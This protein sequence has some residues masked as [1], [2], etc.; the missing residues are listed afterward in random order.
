MKNTIIYSLLICITISV[1]CKSG[2]AQANTN[3]KGKKIALIIA[4]GDFRDEEYEQPKEYF[5][6]NG[7]ITT[8]VS[9]TTNEV[10]G[11]RGMKAKPQLLLKDMQVSNYDGIVFVGGPGA[12]NY[13]KNNNAMRVI[14]DAA[15]K[16][17]VIAAICVAP[18]IL[19]NAGILDG[20][21]ATAWS[22]EVSG[23][24][25]IKSSKSVETD[26]NIVTANG[27]GAA[28]DFAKAIGTALLKH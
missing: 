13:Y 28:L 15:K 16:N 24:N 20:K 22:F 14:K 19:C 4:P 27:P 18:N 8:T 1:Y 26:G 6:S 9:T 21:K 5:E 17:K 2:N 3:L 12:R 7:A 11:S 10:T 23:C 25:V